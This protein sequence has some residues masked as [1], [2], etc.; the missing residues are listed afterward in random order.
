MKVMN[1][2]ESRKAGIEVAAEG[3]RMVE[4][5]GV[6]GGEAMVSLLRE[7]MGA[8]GRCYEGGGGVVEGGGG[9]ETTAF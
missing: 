2:A 5:R 9:G 8:G 6:C 7:V 1:W 3:G 4:R